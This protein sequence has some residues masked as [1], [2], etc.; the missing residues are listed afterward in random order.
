MDV[1][2]NF[3]VGPFSVLLD[4]LPIPSRPANLLLHKL[5]SP[6]RNAG[7][8]TCR[9]V[10]TYEACRSP[11]PL[12]IALVLDRPPSMA[13]GLWRLCELE[14]NRVRAADTH[15]SCG[16]DRQCAGESDL[17]HDFRRDGLLRQALYQQ[18]KRDTN[19]GTV[20]DG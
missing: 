12:F 2:M 4:S 20:D 11:N 13:S 8:G 18:R 7:S 10:N 19:R 5:L 14:R 6:A 15:R 16:G 1:P 3:P 17:E 9:G